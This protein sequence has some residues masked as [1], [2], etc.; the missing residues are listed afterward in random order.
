MYVSADGT[1]ELDDLNAALVELCGKGVDVKM[2]ALADFARA[3]G[4]DAA[5]VAEEADPIEVEPP[6]Y[7]GI[8]WGVGPAW[9]GPPFWYRSCWW[10][11]G[12]FWHD[13]G[14]GWIPPGGFHHPV[15]GPVVVGPPTV[16][17]APMPSRAVAWVAAPRA[18]MFAAR[19]VVG[20]NAIAHVGVRPANF[21]QVAVRASR[22]DGHLTGVR[23]GL[24]GSYGNA[25]AGMFHAGGSNAVMRSSGFHGSGGGGFHAVGSFGRSGSIGRAG[26]FSGG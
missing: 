22:A 20:P 2:V 3:D 9:W 11:G 25:H 6:A 24:S 18:T 14:V 23:A 12:L 13:Y 4:E 8:F 19:A 7:V 10:D 1:Q 5:V 16:H 15:R 17:R 21:G 26:G